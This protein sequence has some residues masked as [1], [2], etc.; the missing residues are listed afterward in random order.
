M[1]SLKL[2]N[3]PGFASSKCVDSKTSVELCEEARSARLLLKYIVILGF[4]VVF[5]DTL[6]HSTMEAGFLGN[7]CVGHA[8][9]FVLA[10]PSLFG[11]AG[12]D[13]HGG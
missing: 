13:S 12:I 1:G 8:S 11:W 5:E 4:S 9:C 3:I 7:S 10:D 2:R 6:D